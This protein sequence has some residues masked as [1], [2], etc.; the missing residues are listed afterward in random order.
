MPR[1]SLFRAGLSGGINVDSQRFDELTARLASGASRRTVL[2]GLT[3]GALAGLAALLGAGIGDPNDV[4]AHRLRRCHTARCRRHR[5][6]HRKQNNTTNAVTINYGDTTLII[7]GGVLPT[8]IIC[9]VTPGA[10]SLCKSGFCN[11][12]T[13]TC[14]GCPDSRVCGE[15]DGLAGMVCCIDG[16]ICADLGCV[17]A[18]D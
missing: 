16:F 1:L 7:N 17:L 10:P 15:D 6:K 14:A 18:G 11:T 3:G 5:R 9:G 12:G 8:G 4:A 2:K 13:N